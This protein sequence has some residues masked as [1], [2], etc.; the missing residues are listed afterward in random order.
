MKIRVKPQP[1]R[2]DSA[3]PTPTGSYE[4]EPGKVGVV[5]D[6][7]MDHLLPVIVHH[8]APP[9]QLRLQSTKPAEA[10]PRT[11]RRRADYLNQSHVSYIIP[12]DTVATEASAPTSSPPVPLADA[13]LQR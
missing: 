4:G 9:P 11:R 8:R 3:A 1:P 7:R 6:H 2:R 10:I 13:Q 12:R 5:E